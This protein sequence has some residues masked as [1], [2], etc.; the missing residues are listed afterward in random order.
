MGGGGRGAL[1]VKVSSLGVLSAIV[2]VMI[3]SKL[4]REK[5]ATENSF[6][7][8]VLK[9][10]ITFRMDRLLS[11]VM[12][13]YDKSYKDPHIAP[14][15]KTRTEKEKNVQGLAMQQIFEPPKK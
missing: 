9:Y 14:S 2:D 4:E 15:L 11:G 5:V 3:S 8:K 10:N 7:L 1:A 12:I 6:T 13:A